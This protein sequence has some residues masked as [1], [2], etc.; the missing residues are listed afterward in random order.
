MAIQLRYANQDETNSAPP[1]RPAPPTVVELA[2][3]MIVVFILAFT[4]L[5]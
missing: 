4:V 3:W 1:K 2:C 5:A